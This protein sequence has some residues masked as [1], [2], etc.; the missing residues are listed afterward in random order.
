[1]ALLVTK[2]V[3]ATT[4]KNPEKKEE[5]AYVIQFTV[6]KVAEKAW[7]VVVEARMRS[8]GISQSKVANTE[9]DSFTTRWKYIVA[10]LK[11]GQEW[12]LK[13]MLMDH[14]RF[15][16]YQQTDKCHKAIWDTAK[17]RTPG[18][19]YDQAKH[20]SYAD[21]IHAWVSLEMVTIDGRLKAKDVNN[22]L[23][24]IRDVHSRNG[25]AFVYIANGPFKVV[26][27]SG[28]GRPELLIAI[29]KYI[30][31]RS[32]QVSKAAV[33]SLFQAHYLE[34]LMKITNSNFNANKAQDAALSKALKKHRTARIIDDTREIADGNGNV[35]ER[36]SYLMW[37]PSTSV[38][39]FL[40]FLSIDH[41][42]GFPARS[43]QSYLILSQTH[44]ARSCAHMLLTRVAH[45]TGNNTLL[46]ICPLG[47]VS[48][49]LAS[50]SLSGSKTI[51]EQ[52][53]RR[54]IFFHF[55]SILLRPYPICLKTMDSPTPPAPCPQEITS[56]DHFLQVHT[57]KEAA[58]AA[59]AAASGNTTANNFPADPAVQQS[60]IQ[61]FHAAVIN[62]DDPDLSRFGET[63]RKKS[64]RA[65]G[66]GTTTIGTSPASSAPPNI[67]AA[68][69]E[70]PAMGD[71]SPV[72]HQNHAPMEQGPAPG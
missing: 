3:H 22:D 27:E 39:I 7:E 64:S 32:S 35:V 20:Y 59:A 23:W 63:K 29:H 46:A 30:V 40:S 21:L 28:Q 6:Q 42:F 60:M 72:V 9:F 4:N 38:S 37:N 11:V 24:D 1:M 18:G 10:T 65:P 26:H 36:T 19:A 16:D 53:N 17:D 66:S 50:L 5:V 31:E 57:V 71:Q 45:A 56:L 41:R 51:T 25:K 43:F 12:A 14:L 55:R 33:H 49:P 67:M 62:T 54:G 70:E 44:L 2:L 34:R 13:L 69:G 68:I 61:D 58:A 15:G 47:L 8:M 48:S 52:N